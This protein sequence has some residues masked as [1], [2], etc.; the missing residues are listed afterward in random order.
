[1]SLTESQRASVWSLLIMLVIAALTVF[2]ITS[3]PGANAQEPQHLVWMASD[4]N[5]QLR[6]GPTGEFW[7]GKEYAPEKCAACF[8]REMNVFNPVVF[9]V[10]VHRVTIDDCKLWYSEGYKPDAKAQK[11]W[12]TLAKWPC[13]QRSE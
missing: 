5:G 6:I 11:F 4:C 13:R 9:H 10:G 3:C 7:Y 1:M 12:E 8:W 2:F